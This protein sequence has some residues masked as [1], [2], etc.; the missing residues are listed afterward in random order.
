LIDYGLGGWLP[1]GIPRDMVKAFDTE[2]AAENKTLLAATQQQLQDA[3]LLADYS[4]KSWY[5]YLGFG[6]SDAEKAY[7]Q[8]AAANA[9]GFNY[10]EFPTDTTNPI[11]DGIGTGLKYAIPIVIGL[12]AFGALNK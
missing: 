1:G 4:K 2:L 12:I 8:R 5:E 6:Y 10:A 9:A 3:K 11:T 7:Q